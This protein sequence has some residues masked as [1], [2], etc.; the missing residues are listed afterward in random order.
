MTGRA[1]RRRDTAP[2]PPAP[3]PPP[4]PPPPTPS[5]DHDANA[6][7]AGCPCHAADPLEAARIALDLAKSELSLET[8]AERHGMSVAAL[9]SWAARPAAATAL[10]TLR[11]LVE[12]QTAARAAFARAEAARALHELVRDGESK[13]T[14]RKACVDLLKLDLDG[15]RNHPDQHDAADAPPHQEPPD[16]LRGLL[17]AFGATRPA[18]TRHEPDQ[19]SADDAA[20]A[21]EGAHDAP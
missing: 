9:A 4:P 13:E 5:D 11:G 8:V 3:S 19:A 2:T 18:A 21:A 7:P 17:E 12:A 14:A 1:K 6:S 16:R 10:R 20:T 15:S